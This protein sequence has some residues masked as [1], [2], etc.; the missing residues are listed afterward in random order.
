MLYYQ[1]V[2]EWC[3]FFNHFN[4]TQGNEPKFIF[5]DDLFTPLSTQKWIVLQIDNFL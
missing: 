4:K 5:F 1:L 3:L 2:N